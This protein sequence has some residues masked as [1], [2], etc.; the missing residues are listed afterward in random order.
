MGTTSGPPRRRVAFGDEDPGYIGLDEG[1][2]GR[3]GN[4]PLRQDGA[5]QPD[6]RS[7]VAVRRVGDRPGG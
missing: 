3:D 2:T 6:L 1:P 5:I 4:V 7:G